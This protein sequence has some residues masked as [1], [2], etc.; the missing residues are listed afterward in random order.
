MIKQKEARA[1]LAVQDSSDYKISCPR[2]FAVISG[3]NDFCPE[4]GYTLGGGEGSDTAVYQDLA[5]AN[6]AR[7]RGEKQG[8]I[9]Q[10]LKVLREYPNNV[11][12]HS[13]LGEIYM[14][15]G[16]LKQA[17]EWFEMALDLD[18]KAARER[19]LLN[20]VKKQME[21]SE[22]KA[23]LQQLEVKPKSGLTL[24]W[25][26]MVGVI[27]IVMIVSFVIGKNSA[28]TKVIAGNQKPAEPIRIPAQT[29]TEPVKESG[30]PPAGATVITEDQTALSIIK[31]N[32]TASN[33]ILTVM[34]N[35]AHEEI[36]LTGMAEAQIPFES[37][38][39]VLASD[40]FVNRGSTRMATIR[41]IEG[42]KVVFVGSIARDIYDELQANSKGAQIDQLGIQA[43]P[44]AWHLDP[45]T[46]PGSPVKPTDTGSTEEPVTPD[47]ESKTPPTGTGISTNPSS[48]G[49]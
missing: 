29:N 38:A 33:L 25:A 27:V 31:T 40:V 47:S 6:L 36:I 20:K 39:L 3:T 17:S 1:V 10:C 45:A 12:A 16:E 49:N 30:G 18:P 22:T 11:T 26:S 32:A 5:Q 46:K 23:T 14:E 28:G 42:G 24:L 44:D 7:M 19:Q 4:C 35:P 8:A 43:F 48:S 37:T 13:L 41:L 9:D 21:D 34:L 15:H 2:C